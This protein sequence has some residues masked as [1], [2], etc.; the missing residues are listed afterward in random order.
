MTSMR[1]R[2][3]LLAGI[4]AAVLLTALSIGEESESPRP[5]YVGS[6][7]CKVCHVEIFNS[8]SETPHARALATLKGDDAGKTTCLE[9]HTT[10]FGAGGFGGEA[11]MP[12]LANVQ[13]EACHGPG[14]LYSF[15]SVMLD[16]EL[17]S[18]AGLVAVDSLTCTRCH[19][20]RSPTFKDFAFK[21]GL[22]TGTH[23]RKRD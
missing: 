2:T 15:S 5:K 12:D 10:G 9:C 22:L 21:T 16:P 1:A 17:S 18:K 8:W 13:C 4:P 14:S 11:R 7:K 6:I 23:S 19:N 3:I 20:A